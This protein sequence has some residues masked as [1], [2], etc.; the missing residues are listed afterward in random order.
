MHD[1]LWIE[2]LGEPIAVEGQTLDLAVWGG[3]LSGLMD[4]P[5]TLLATFTTEQFEVSPVPEG[6]PP[7]P[8]IAH[9]EDLGGGFGIFS[10]TPPPGT[11]GTVF[12]VKFKAVN[13]FFQNG[14]WAR[15]PIMPSIWS[16]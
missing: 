14:L 6:E 8:P 7:P 3:N 11:A 9:F 13:P 4:P 10:L 5:V 12:E 15:I 2:I 1:A 16:P